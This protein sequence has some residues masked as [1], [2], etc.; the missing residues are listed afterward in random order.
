[1]TDEWMLPLLGLMRKAG[2]LSLGEENC[3]KAV[4]SRKAILILLASDA[5]ANAQKRAYSLSSGCDLIRLPYDK[6]T[7]S[8]ALGFPP[9]SIAAVCDAGFAK[10]FRDRLMRT[11]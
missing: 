11:E 7:L 1:M 9:V 8:D 3:R 5:S 10:I 4:R 2:K 6:E